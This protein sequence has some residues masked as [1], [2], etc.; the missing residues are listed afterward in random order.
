MLL[1]YVYTFVELALIRNIIIII[2]FA[3]FTIIRTMAIIIV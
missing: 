3:L 2:N 1:M